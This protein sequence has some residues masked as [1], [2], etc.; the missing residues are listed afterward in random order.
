LGAAEEDVIDL[1]DP[2]R[3]IKGPTRAH[4]VDPVPATQPGLSAADI[5]KAEQERVAKEQAEKLTFEH[6]VEIFS[7]I[8]SEKL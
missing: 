5:A 8:L 1:N 6:F 7:R 4:A 2:N 3:K